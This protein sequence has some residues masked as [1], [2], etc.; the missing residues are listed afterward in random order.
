MKWSADFDSFSLFTKV[1]LH[2]TVNVEHNCV[3]LPGY[4][5]KIKGHIT[6]YPLR[7]FFKKK[8]HNCILQPK[9]EQKKQ[10][11]TTNYQLAHS[12]FDWLWQIKKEI[13]NTMKNDMS[14]LNLK[15]WVD[16]SFPSKLFF[17]TNHQDSRLNKF[18]AIDGA[19]HQNG[20]AQGHS[21][22][23]CCK[24]LLMGKISSLRTCVLEN[25]VLVK[26]L[27]KVLSVSTSC[28]KTIQ[29]WISSYLLRM[30]PDIRFPDTRVYL[31]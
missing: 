14:T 8:M 11:F 26:M 3:L 13:K 27:L 28:S 30:F 20:K 16:T 2:F 23:H 18:F 22:L 9:T 24:Y 6:V 1:E 19:N 10:Q 31:I 4:Q 15:V 12:N 5:K 29:F 7:V 17:D 25:V 21:N